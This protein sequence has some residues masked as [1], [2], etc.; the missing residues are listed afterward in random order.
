VSPSKLAAVSLT[1]L[2]LCAITPTAGAAPREIVIANENLVEAGDLLDQHLDRFL[3]RIEQVTGWPKNSLKGKAVVR[4]V[5]ALDY[6][7]KN[8]S[9]FAILPIHQVVEGYKDLKLELLGRAVGLEGTELYNAGVARFPK[10][11]VELGASHS[12]KVAGP[13]VRDVDWLAIISDST[14]TRDKPAALV[15]VPSSQEAFK[16]LEQKKVDVAIV[17]NP[18]WRELEK[19]TTGNKPDLEFVFGSP[20]LPP[21][22]VVAVGKFASAADRKKF[23]A[24]LDKICK[25]SGAEPCG[26]VGLM[27]IQ[28]GM[29]QHHQKVLDHY[30]SLKTTK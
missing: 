16:L 11:F 23:A 5:E 14:I 4:P 3:R 17:S 20:K 25:E 12:I 10:N 24:A 30:Q 21:S 13:E 18:M 6:I 1:V 15:E 28:P 8:R 22:A 9:A 19:R 27:Y 7:R 29:T 26:R 2:T